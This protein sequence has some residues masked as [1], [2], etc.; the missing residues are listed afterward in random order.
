[1]MQRALESA[2]E[3][4]HLLCQFASKLL[5]AATSDITEAEIE[6]TSKPSVTEESSKP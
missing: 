3:R 1:M 5:S 4:D 2:V 6:R